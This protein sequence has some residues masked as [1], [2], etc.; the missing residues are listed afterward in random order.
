MCEKRNHFRVCTNKEWVPWLTIS[1]VTSNAYNL[2]LKPHLI[3]P[4]H[5]LPLLMHLV[6]LLP[7]LLQRSVI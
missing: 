1:S 6:L 7:L 2:L 5:K 4:Q 3:L